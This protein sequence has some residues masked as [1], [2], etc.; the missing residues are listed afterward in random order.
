[1]ANRD[2]LFRIAVRKFEPF[3]TALAKQWECFEQ[4]HRTGLTLDVVPL[5]LHP[6]HDS[7]FVN[8]GLQL[9]DWDA[10][11]IST[12]WLAQAADE[13]GLVNL[14][15]YIERSPP[16]GYPDAWSKSLLRL[17]NFDGVVLGLPYH[18]GPECLIYR[19]DLLEDAELADR[20]ALQFGEPL[21]VPQTWDQFHRISRFL[22]DPQ[23]SI[24]GTAFAA[25]PDGHN[26]VY[27]FCLQL[28]TR[29]G[30]LF[31]DSGR[32]LLATPKACEALDFY[33]MLLK[34]TSAVHPESRAFDSVKSGLAFAA[35]QI[36]MMVNWFGFASMSETVAE[37]KVKGRVGVAPI[38]SS[39]GPRVSL[40]AYW[41]L[42]IPAGS[43][44]RDL[45]WSFLCY[46]TSP[47]MDRLLTL[48]GAIGCRKS[49]WSDAKV[50]SV[51]PFFHCLE[52]LHDDARELPR[53]RSWSEL[54]TV[55]DRM[56]LDAIDSEDSTA[57]IVQRAQTCAD[58]YA[59]KEPN[60]REP[61]WI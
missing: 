9:G 5:E 35:G 60:T 37:S 25:F 6:L 15:P 50:N 23:K 31:D 53:L 52:S 24:Y 56:V 17:Q 11:L 58:K 57:A 40:N 39:V 18:N 7:L 55:I 29:G 54:A 49:T 14:A 3:E 43:W 42:G 20:Y 59:C 45:A 30:E 27:D 36:A 32:L 41:I 46:S 28:W 1:M 22:T 61:W 48:E 38:P 2:Q 44:H 51:I 8:R 47:A 4:H 34:D 26:T 16:E 33:R 10:A 21:T 19:K 13:K 12:D